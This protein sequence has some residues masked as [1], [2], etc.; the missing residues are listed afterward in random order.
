MTGT[1]IKTLKTDYQ[2]NWGS[3]DPPANVIID[4][5]E[6][7]MCVYTE[8]QSGKSVFFEDKSYVKYAG[9]F[10]KV[11]SEKLFVFIMTDNTMGNPSSCLHMLVFTK[12]SPEPKTLSIDKN[13]S[14]FKLGFMYVLGNTDDAIDYSGTKDGVLKFFIKA[15]GILR[16]VDRSV[17]ADKYFFGVRVFADTY[18]NAN[19]GDVDYKLE[20]DYTLYPRGDLSTDISDEVTSYNIENSDYQNRYSLVESEIAYIAYS[21]LNGNKSYK[22]SNVSGN[23]DELRVECQYDLSNLRQPSAGMTKYDQYTMEDI[24]GPDQIIEYLLT[25]TVT[26]QMNRTISVFITSRFGL[27]LTEL[28]SGTNI[29]NVYVEFSSNISGYIGQEYSS[30]LFSVPGTVSIDG[31]GIIIVMSGIVATVENLIIN[32]QLTISLIGS[33]VISTP[34]LL[35]NGELT[36]FNYNNERGKSDEASLTFD[37]SG[38]IDSGGF[39]FNIYP[40]ARI[41]FRNGTRKSNTNCS[42]SIRV[43]ENEFYDMSKR[44]KVMIVGF[45]SVDIECDV[46][47][48]VTASKILDISSVS[49]VNINRYTRN[50][51][52]K[53]NGSD[54][55]IKDADNVFISN[56]TYDIPNDMNTQMTKFTGG[57]VIAFYDCHKNVKIVIDRSEVTSKIDTNLSFLNVLQ[58]TDVKLIIKRTTVS[59][60]VD[61]LAKLMKNLNYKTIR[62]DRSNINCEGI[63]GSPIG[64]VEIKDSQLYFEDTLVTSCSTFRVSDSVLEFKRDLNVSGDTMNSFEI[65]RSV[66]G[67]QNI[68]VSCN[69]MKSSILMTDSNLQTIGSV[70]IKASTI[71]IYSCNLTCKTLTV[72]AIVFK[73]SSTTVKTGSS[74]HIRQKFTLGSFSYSPIYTPYDSNVKRLNSSIEIKEK[75]KR[76]SLSFKPELGSDVSLECTLNVPEKTHSEVVSQ[77]INVMNITVDPNNEMTHSIDLNQDAVI[78]ATFPKK[79]KRIVYGTNKYQI[80]RPEPFEYE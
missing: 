56:V 48:H 79:L 46:D 19:Y 4:L 15:D 47:K 12:D 70:D 24:L 55:S 53:T 9:V 14:N 39:N 38:N 52:N 41:V 7:Y 10:C 66:I 58:N 20:P 62:I 78:T 45:N 36:V 68:S 16:N 8:S 64:T 23:I 27:F 72:D 80:Q 26:D 42:A 54:I 77:F 75:Y 65:E 34:N 25:G 63:L 71:D 51:Y 35:L 22:L 67:C 59:R 5:Y 74:G 6:N 3:P 50:A 28:M 21:M 1:F 31:S 2:V 33:N 61:F 44:P 37:V 49:D 57:S 43:F 30:K 76:C 18:S 40:N 13:F 32:S 60:T 17:D 29:K 73:L 11:V 69:D